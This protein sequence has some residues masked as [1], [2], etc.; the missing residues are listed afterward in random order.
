M[1]VELRRL[2]GRLVVESL[3]CIDV[4]KITSCTQSQMRLISRLHIPTKTVW[5]HTNFYYIIIPFQSCR[6]Q[7]HAYPVRVSPSPA[8]IR[9]FDVFID[10]AAWWRLMNVCG[11]ALYTLMFPPSIY[12]VVQNKLSHSQW[13][14]PPYT[15]ITLKR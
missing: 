7:G 11:S 6:V 15:G 8:T 3:G 1:L 14:F 9:R 5:W 12:C 4:D 10:S 13:A 2:A